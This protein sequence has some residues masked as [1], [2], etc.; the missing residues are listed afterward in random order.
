MVVVVG[1]RAVVVEEGILVLLYLLVEVVL[2][3]L[4]GVRERANVRYNLLLRLLAKDVIDREGTR[5]K[6]R[7]C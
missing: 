7:S 4:F 1:L 5:V 3:E 2:W 6:L